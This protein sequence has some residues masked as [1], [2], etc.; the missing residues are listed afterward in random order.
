VF[1]KYFLGPIY[2]FPKKKKKATRKPRGEWELKAMRK[3]NDSNSCS[4]SL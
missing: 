4:P 2:T 1:L 3:R